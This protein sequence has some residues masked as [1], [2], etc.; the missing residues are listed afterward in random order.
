MDHDDNPLK[1]LLD[2]ILELK[3]INEHE[4]EE[5]MDRGAKAF[6]DELRNGYII[7]KLALIAVPQYASTYRTDLCPSAVTR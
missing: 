2:W 1:P 4:Y 7:G 6:F 5:F 3:V